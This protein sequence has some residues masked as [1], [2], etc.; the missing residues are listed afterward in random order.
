M[1][2]TRQ[3]GW[4]LG[5]TQMTAWATTYYVPAVVTVGVAATFDASIALVL[6]G[7]SLGMLVSGLCSPHVGRLID[8]HGGR[9]VLVTSTLLQAAG[10]LTLAASGGLGT[11]YA[12]WAVLG[13]GM[14]AGLYDAAFAT[15]GR[16]LG[17]AARPAIT[18]IT[19]LGGFA[20]SLGWPMGAALVAVGGWRMTL[21]AYAGIVLCVNLPL[22]LAFVPRAV[23]LLPTAT[24]IAHTPP[25]HA[26]RA[27]VLIASFFTLRAAIATIITVSAPALLAGLGLGTIEAVAVAALIGPAQVASRLV[28]ATAGR[29]LSPLTTTWIGATVLPVVTLA[30]VLAV[31]TPGVPLYAGVL[32]FVLGY[33]MSNGILTISRGVLPLWMFGADGYAAR[34]GRIALPVLLAQ[35]AAPTIAAALFAGWPAERMFMALGALSVLAAACLV[36][37]R[38]P[39]N[40]PPAS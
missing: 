6:G 34:I 27:F 16:A 20:S 2:P 19:L 28:Q 36:P 33:G 9:P 17:T 38:P 15:A 8:R 37:L 7:F 5:F 10:L 4:V 3:L 1:T 29:G 23:P 12:G 25:A 22:F 39:A 26:S 21:L 32:V 18:G 35:A 31:A 24:A 30:L 11:W 14:A 13:V 40:Q